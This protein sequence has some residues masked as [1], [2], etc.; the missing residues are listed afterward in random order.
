MRT[1]LV[2]VVLWLVLVGAG[3]TWAWKASQATRWGEPIDSICVLKQGE[4][5]AAQATVAGFG[6]RC[7]SGREYSELPRLEQAE[8]RWAFQGEFV[9]GPAERPRTA[10][11]GGGSVTLPLGEL[12]EGAYELVAGELKVAFRIPHEQPRLCAKR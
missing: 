9:P 2:T 5:T 1:N 10:D 12:K 4:K 3:F 7:I 6:T 8:G 11:C